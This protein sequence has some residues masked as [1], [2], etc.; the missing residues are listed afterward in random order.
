MNNRFDAKSLLIGLLA[1]VV[2]AFAVG[3]GNSS[4]QVGRYQIAGAGNHALVVDTATGQVWQ[5]YMDRDEG[6][7]DADFFKAKI[8]GKK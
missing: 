2:L 3:A 1:G 7:T 5:A 8:E 6:L 4:N